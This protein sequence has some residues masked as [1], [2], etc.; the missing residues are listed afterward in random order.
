MPRYSSSSSQ[1][2][3]IEKQGDGERHADAMHAGRR[4][5]GGSSRERN[6]RRTI[7]NIHQFCEGKSQG[8]AV[9]NVARSRWYIFGNDMQRGTRVTLYRPWPYTIIP[10]PLPILPEENYIT[11]H[12]LAGFC[13]K[14]NTQPSSSTDEL[15]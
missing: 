1:W 15:W 13:R 6:Q 2:S 8:F 5:S 10:C 4:R 3:D 11:V 12:G 9:G 7:R 14:S